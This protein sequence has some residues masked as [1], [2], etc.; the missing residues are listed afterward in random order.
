VP[1]RY[2][3]RVADASRMRTGWEWAYQV[4]PTHRI[5][6]IPGGT[7]PWNRCLE[8][9]YLT[10]LFYRGNQLSLLNELTTMYDIVNAYVYGW[11]PAGTFG[12]GISDPTW[13][14]GAGKAAFGDENV[15]AKDTGE[16]IFAH[17]IAH[18]LGRRHTNTVANINDPNCRTNP[19]GNTPY[20]IAIVDPQSDWILDD[21]SPGGPPFPN[22]KIQTWGLDGYGFGW[23]VSSSSAIKNP[24]NTYDY[25]SYCGRL[26]NNNVWTSPWTYERIFDRLQ[27][28]AN[29]ALV[30]SLAGAEPYFIASGLVFTDDTAIL[31][32]VWVI[33]T[34]TPAI[35]PPPGTEQCLEA[36]DA[37]NTPLVSHCFDLPFTDYETGEPTEV[38]GFHFMLPYPD[39]VARIVLKQGAIILTSQVVSPNAPDVTVLSPNGGENWSAT[40]NYTISWAGNDAD[41]DSLTYMVHYSADGTEWIPVGGIITATQLTVNAAELPGG[42]SS[43]VRVIASDGI[44]TSTDESNAPFTVARKA[45]QA[46]IVSPERDG[47]I[48]LDT[49]LFL[50]GYSYDLEDGLLEGESLRW[51]SNRDGDLGTGSQVLA[52]LSP[53]QHLITFEATDSHNN[54]TTNTLH[55]YVGYRAYLPVVVK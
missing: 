51:H 6:Y 8:P 50:M 28:S 49:P 55:I 12:G 26:S 29:S 46:L 14:G 38:D 23:L 52:T 5:N 1:I 19:E 36:Q 33:T 27:P 41:G 16:R 7:L 4:F 18:L 39:G 44:N 54:T 25:M 35:T 53:G 30:Q 42:N 24:N 43:L 22:S 10:C 3:G 2:F 37:A 15:P 48:P 40:G 11:L 9:N 17:E 13:A 20:E 31:D 47:T 45:P 34:T 32:P 21:G